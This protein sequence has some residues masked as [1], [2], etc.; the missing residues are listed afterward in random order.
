MEWII[1]PNLA[2]LLSVQPDQHCKY[3]LLVYVI[4]GVYQIGLSSEWSC[5]VQAA[6]IENSAS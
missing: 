5:A 3:S 2:K 6:K 1:S 4:V